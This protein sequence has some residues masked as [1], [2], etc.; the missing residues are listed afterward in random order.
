MREQMR[1]YVLAQYEEAARSGMPIIRPL[2]FDFWNDT[3]A[4]SV[5]DQQMFGPDYLV[6]PVLVK[7]ASM[8]YVYLPQLPLGTVWRNVFTAVETDTSAGGKNITE[9]TPLNSFPLY[10][11]T[12]LPPPP[13]MPPTC[14]NTCTIYPNMDVKIPGR[15]LGHNASTSDSECCAMCKATAGC[16]TFVRGP[17]NQSSGTGPVT[18]FLLAG[19]TGYMHAVQHR[20]LGCLHGHTPG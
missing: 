1:P 11:R 7:G 5:S 19:A 6:A 2:F 12:S 16:D 17:F 8:R 3:R 20:S 14:N 15:A 9:A 18:C 13:P 4:Q 10:R